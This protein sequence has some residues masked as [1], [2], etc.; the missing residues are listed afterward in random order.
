[1]PLI[2]R[3]NDSMTL[4][5]SAMDCDRCKIRYDQVVDLQEAVH[6]RLHAGYGSAWGDD[7][8]VDVVLCDTCTHTLLSPFAHVTDLSDQPPKKVFGLHT[9]FLLDANLEFAL[10][11]QGPDS[12]GGPSSK[13]HRA[14]SRVRYALH[15]VVVPLLVLWRL[16]IT[17]ATHAL[18][19]LSAEDAR[20]RERYRID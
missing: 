18:R 16:M 13:A 17:P 11:S 9:R 20:L 5:V 4:V 7:N 6:V 1:M 2:F 8:L 3:K 14:L 15:W 12:T 19:W 10:A